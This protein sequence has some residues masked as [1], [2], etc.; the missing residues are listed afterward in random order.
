VSLSAREVDRGD[1]QATQRSNSLTVGAL[2]EGKGDL[3]AG[4]SHELVLKALEFFEE[5]YRSNA[6]IAEDAPINIFYRRRLS[7]AD[8][9][10]QS[11]VGSAFFNDLR[12]EIREPGVS[13]NGF[14]SLNI[15]LYGNDPLRLTPVAFITLS[16]GAGKFNWRVDSVSMD[17]KLGPQVEVDQSKVTKIFFG[18]QAPEINSFYSPDYSFK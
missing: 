5:H 8:G 14:N 12:I 17:Y 10:A 1:G 4:T 18:K 2:K 7:E 15:L 13:Q 16:R 9:E 11:E 3:V 6:G